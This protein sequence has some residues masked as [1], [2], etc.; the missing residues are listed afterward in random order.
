[1]LPALSDHSPNRVFIGIVAGMASGVLYSL[2]I[3]LVSASFRSPDLSTEVGGLGAVTM[4]GF[5]V[6][7]APLAL[8]FFLTCLFVLALRLTSQILLSRVAIDAASGLRRQ[9]YERVADAPISTVERFGR[10]RLI[11]A[12]SQDVPR[13]MIGAQAGPDLLINAV[14]LCGML[15]FL[16]ILNFNVFVFVLQCILVGSVTYQVPM[17]IGRRFFR[18]V[19][20]STDGVQKAFDILVSGLKELKL[21]RSKRIDFF[22][23]TL[24]QREREMVSNQKKGMAVMSMARAYG[25]M[26]CYFLIG[27]ISFIFVNYHA[28]PQH[29]LVSIVMALL[30]VTGPIG[31]ILNAI[32]GLVTSQI[33]YRRVKLL[34][35]QLPNEDVGREIN[36]VIWGKVILK[37]VCY[38]Y[39]DAASDRIVNL[40]PFN[41]EF[42]KG[43]IT[44]IVGGNGSGKSTLCK[45]LTTHYSPTK[46]EIYFGETLVRPETTESVRQTITAIYS[47]YHLF[48]KV[49]GEK[50]DLIAMNHF[51][52]LLDLRSKVQYENNCFSTLN[53]SDG[54]RRRLALVTAFLEDRELILFD[55]WAADQD[56]QFKDVFYREILPALRDSGKAVIAITHDDQYFSLADKVIRLADGEVTSIHSKSDVICDLSREKIVL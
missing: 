1:M 17:I 10:A 24:V 2:L 55:E 47:D 48:E 46:G 43:E 31:M 39:K 37:D 16:S 8:I 13:I 5:E 41:L 3:P 22:S 36:P 44:F 4:F 7:N 9:L 56:P 6:A 54:Q 29:D 49:Y 21:H 33:S 14:T 11:T 18:K 42:I 20:D 32:P 40:G 51:L 34:L 12:V 25:D 53:L 52:D 23:E 30:Y 45:I 26:L 38:Q 19:A 15:G 35:T 50:V 28:I 27:A